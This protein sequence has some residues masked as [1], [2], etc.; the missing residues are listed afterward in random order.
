[1]LDPCIDNSLYSVSGRLEIL[2]ENHREYVKRTLGWKKQMIGKELVDIFGIERTVSSSKDFPATWHCYFL[3]DGHLA[4]RLQL[5]APAMM[6][7]LHLPLMLDGVFSV[8]KGQIPVFEK[9]P[10]LW[11]EDMELYSK[12]LDRKMAVSVQKHKA[13]MLSLRRVNILISKTIYYCTCILILLFMK[14]GP[15]INEI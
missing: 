1:M 9:K 6:K 7:I 4:S 10:L 8:E 14:T 12:F 13:K 3:S 2:E 11:D 15:Q 5:G